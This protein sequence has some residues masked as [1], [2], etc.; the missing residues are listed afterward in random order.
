MPKYALR[1]WES[2]QY[3]SVPRELYT[4]KCVAWIPMNLKL[5]GYT[6]LQLPQKNKSIYVTKTKLCLDE[7]NVNKPRHIIM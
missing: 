6:L 5:T 3:V 4:P 7:I 2:M 1:Q